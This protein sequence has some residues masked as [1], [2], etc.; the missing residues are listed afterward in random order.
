M[1]FLGVTTSQ[2]IISCDLHNTLNETVSG[3]SFRYRHWWK[4]VQNADTCI[5]NF[6][7]YG[8]EPSFHLLSQ[9][10]LRIVYFCTRDEKKHRSCFVGPDDLYSAD[11]ELDDPSFWWNWTL[12]VVFWLLYN[13]TEGFGYSRLIIKNRFCHEWKKTTPRGTLTAFASFS[14]FPKTIYMY[15]YQLRPPHKTVV[16][17]GL[18][19]LS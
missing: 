10:I 16:Y 17:Y 1:T 11:V 14:E 12:S 2:G 3:I 15:C 8:I 9:S 19:R 18:L 7:R 5:F 4:S 13:E 6:L